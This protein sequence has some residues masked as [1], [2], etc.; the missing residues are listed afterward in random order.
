MGLGEGQCAPEEEAG[1][2]GL[3]ETLGVDGRPRGPDRQ[4]GGGN[5]HIDVRPS[6]DKA[7]ITQSELE[8]IGDGIG[9]GEVVPGTDVVSAEDS[10]VGFEADQR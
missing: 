5:A 10:V 9:P 2:V 4:G 8:P 6:A 3:D 1:G 7:S